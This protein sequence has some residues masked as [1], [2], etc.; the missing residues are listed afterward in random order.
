MS[1]P[2]PTRLVL[3]ARDESKHR[4]EPYTFLSLIIKKHRK[5]KKHTMA[6]PVAVSTFVP[7]AANAESYLERRQATSPIGCAISNYLLFTI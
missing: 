6:T 3:A 1:R 4:P 7:L 2:F 5:L